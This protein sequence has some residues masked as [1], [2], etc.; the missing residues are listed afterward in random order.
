[1]GF[2]SG[3]KGLIFVSNISRVTGDFK[4]V[5]CNALVRIKLHSFTSLILIFFGGGRG[6]AVVQPV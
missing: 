6:G 1:M 2:N 3:F 5:D 4:N